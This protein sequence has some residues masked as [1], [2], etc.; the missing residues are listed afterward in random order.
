MIPR[1]QIIGKAQGALNDTLTSIRNVVS[2]NQ[3]S[4]KKKKKKKKKPQ[5]AGSISSLDV[6]V[7]MAEVYRQQ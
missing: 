5:E 6:T 2:P 1:R 3:K 7:T 4:R